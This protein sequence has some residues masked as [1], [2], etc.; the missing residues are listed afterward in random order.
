VGFRWGVCCQFADGG[1]RI[2]QATR[3]YVATLENDDRLFAVRDLLP[4][5]TR[6]GVP[7][8]YDVHHHR[9]NPDGLDVE[10]ATDLAVAVSRSP[11]ERLA[12]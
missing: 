2:R 9:C 5:C 6:T 10:A 4:L 7:L 12:R 3:R 11:R 8:V 1:V